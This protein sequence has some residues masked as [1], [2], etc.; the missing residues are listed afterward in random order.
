ML[1][2]VVIALLAATGCNPQVA[3]TDKRQEANEAVTTATPEKEK[4]MEE[5]TR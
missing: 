1:L 4:P 3:A 2:P 5:D